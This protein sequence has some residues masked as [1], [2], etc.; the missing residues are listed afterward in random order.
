MQ[1]V[2]F[3]FLIQNKK[4]CGI[5]APFI[6]SHAN[7]LPANANNNNISQSHVLYGACAWEIA[8]SAGILRNPSSSAK[9]GNLDK[10]AK[11]ANVRQ[12]VGIATNEIAPEH[13]LLSRRF[14]IRLLTGVP[15]LSIVKSVCIALAWFEYVLLAECKCLLV[16]MRCWDSII[17]CFCINLGPKKHIIAWWGGGEQS[18][19]ICILFNTVH[20]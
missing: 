16:P 7:C 12:V 8:E 10:K 18:W 15:R 17:F 20:I 11:V 13:I 6:Y 5:R 1:F 19:H 9:T 2:L 14:D 3:S 4:T